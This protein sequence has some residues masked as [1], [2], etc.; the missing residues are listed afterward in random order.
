ML[1]GSR[2]EVNSVS[3]QSKVCT[4]CGQDKP[5]DAFFPRPNRPCGYS[6]QCRQCESN[7]KKAQRASDPTVAERERSRCKQYRAE[8]LDELRAHDR[9][10]ARTDERRAAK[11]EYN[12][13]SFARSYAT[14]KAY[15]LSKYHKRRVLLE[16]AGTYT[17]EEW[18][19]LCSAFDNRCASCRRAL[20]L[21]CDHIIPLSKGGQNSLANLQP[22]C[23]PC[24]SSKGDKTIDFR[25][26]Y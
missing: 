10:R 16:N 6:S 1:H 17:Q 9:E 24:N 7:R 20:P 2:L 26:I 4:I 19:W 3:N 18:D 14:N 8:H 23:Q 25:F 12:R 5:L 22:L 11:R 15:W 21:A 13:R